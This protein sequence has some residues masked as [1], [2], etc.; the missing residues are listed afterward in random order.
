[1]NPALKEFVGIVRR[2]PF[3]SCCIVV[4][5]VVS[6]ANYFLWQRLQAITTQYE[7]VR[8]SGETIFTALSS[9]GRINTQLATVEEALKKIDQN[10]ITETDIGENYAYFYQI[11]TLS[12]VHLAPLNQLS[13]QPANEGVPY[14]TIPFTMRATGTYPQ[15]IG[16]LR[17]LEN[18]PRQLRIRTFDFSRG[19]GKGNLIAVELTVELL[20]S[21]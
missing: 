20:G 1:M 13:S 18:G 14:K 12:R 7:E 15:I 6:T 5:L 4:F 8:H 16:F 10:L 17:E 9:H 19:D 2:S 3:L 21:P 11:E